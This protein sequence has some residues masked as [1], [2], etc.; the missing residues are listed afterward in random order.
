[1]LT[2][3]VGRKQS[4]PLQLARGEQQLNT[5]EITVVPADRQL[6]FLPRGRVV[7][8]RRKWAGSFQPAIDQVVSD[9]ARVYKHN[10]GVIIFSGTCND[11]EV[12]CRVVKACGGSVWTQSPESCISPAMPDAAMST[13]CVSFQGTP[14]QLALALAK[15]YG[16]E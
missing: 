11:G 8:T 7:E 4:Y 16:I 15:Q 1:M 3:S 2:A 10:M 14:E 6:R 5:G 12:G 9:L 13:G